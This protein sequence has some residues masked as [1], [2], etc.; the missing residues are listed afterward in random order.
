MDAHVGARPTRAY[1]R[2]PWVEMSVACFVQGKAQ[3]SAAEDSPGWGSGG[4][5]G[6]RLLVPDLP[7]QH[8][9]RA[10]AGG[11][12]L[13]GSQ[14]LRAWARASTR[15]TGWG[16]AGFR[17]TLLPRPGAILPTSFCPP[18]PAWPVQPHKAFFMPGGWPG[19]PEGGWGRRGGSCTHGQGTSGSIRGRPRHHPLCALGLDSR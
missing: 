9:T 6:F 13:C 3:G 18:T 5:R 10:V 16:L 19:A 11:G 15:I 7:T 2:L 4:R 1:I 14:G 17:R 12:R 8:R